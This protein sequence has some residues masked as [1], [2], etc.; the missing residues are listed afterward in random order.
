ML[1][2]MWTMPAAEEISVKEEPDTL[3]DFPHSSQSGYTD[4]Q[5]LVPLPT[6]QSDYP[7]ITISELTSPDSSCYSM[8]NISTSLEQGRGR[9]RSNSGSSGSSANSAS[10]GGQGQARPAKIRRRQPL[11]EEELYQQRNQA[12]VRERQRTQSLNEAFTKL[13]EIVPTQPSDKLSK[14]ETLKLA[15]MYIDFLN[16]VL[17]QGQDGYDPETQASSYLALREDLQ[18]AF[19]IWRMSQQA[20]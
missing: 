11:S 2:T 14:R 8:S 17:E 19:N 16:K 6:F 7:T 9:K 18:Q 13:R 4:L 10:C 12:N 15:N 20:K 3:S 1:N 5:T